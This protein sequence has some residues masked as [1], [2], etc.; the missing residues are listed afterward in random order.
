N[1]RGRIAKAN[2]GI[3]SV[4]G[5]F[6]RITFTTQRHFKITANLGFVFHQQNGLAVFFRP[7]LKN[8]PELPYTT[9]NRAFIR[10]LFES[11]E[12]NGRTNENLVPLTVGSAQIRP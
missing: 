5:R 4:S 9:A 2:E 12:P 3:F 1:G 11:D 8:P 10:S 6:H 7:H